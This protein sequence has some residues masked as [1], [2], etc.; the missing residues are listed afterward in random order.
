MP[1]YLVVPGISLIVGAWVFNVMAL[2]NLVDER[3]ETRRK[4]V[5]LNSFAPRHL[6]TDRGWRYR[7]WS[8]RCAVAWLL[9][10][11]IWGVT[12]MRR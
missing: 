2:D 10:V 4:A 5:S 7:R 12:T 6:F 3:D 11:L 1:W 9:L 8:I